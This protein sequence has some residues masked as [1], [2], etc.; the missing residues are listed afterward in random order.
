M[1]RRAGED[2]RNFWQRVEHAARQLADPFDL[3]PRSGRIEFDYDRTVADDDG[4]DNGDARYAYR[5]ELHQLCHSE[6]VRV[7]LKAA[8]AL[9][10]LAQLVRSSRRHREAE[11]LIVR[12]RISSTTRTR[13]AKLEGSRDG[14]VRKVMLVPPILSIDA[15]EAEAMASQALLCAATRVG[16]DEPREVQPDPM[17]KPMVRG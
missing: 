13:L 3:Y 11:A 15:W 14:R 2:D 17:V 6:N 8:I 1:F 16:V 12:A 4:G 5:M 9:G 7:R 10:G